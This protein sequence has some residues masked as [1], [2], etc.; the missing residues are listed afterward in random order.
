MIMYSTSK[1]IIVGIWFNEKSE[2]STIYDTIFRIVS[3]ENVTATSTK[4]IFL[5]LIMEIWLHFR[6]GFVEAQ[7]GLLESLNLQ[8]WPL[9]K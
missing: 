3:R 2:A 7:F 1:S 9:F 6:I 8:V 4:R 5:F